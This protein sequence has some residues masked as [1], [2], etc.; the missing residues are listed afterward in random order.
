MN[1]F[2]SAKF[3]QG[4]PE[5]TED[6]A[7][8]KLKDELR[9]SGNRYRN[10]FEGSKDMIFITSLDGAFQD[11][12]PATVE[13]LGY[14]GKEDVLSLAYVEKIFNKKD[15]WEVFKRQI[16]H[17]GFV[18][19]FETH[20]KKADGHLIHCLVSG[21]AVSGKGQ[22]VSGYIGIAKDI[23]ARM[24]AIRNFRQRHR[25][26]RILNSVAY[27]MNKTQDLRT[28]LSTV[29]QKTLEA[30]NLSSGAIFLIDHDVSAF[31]L[32]AQ[33]GLS[34][35]IPKETCRAELHDKLLMESLLNKD[36]VLKPEPIFP[37]FKA[38]LT[39]PGNKET[40]Q[41][42]CFLITAKGKPTG[43][44]GL[45][46][47]PDRDMAGG[48]DFNL[49]GSLGNFLGGAIEKTILIHE[50]RR[51]QAELKELNANLFRL[52]ENERQRIAR[53]LHDEAGQALTG[54]RYSLESIENNL[55][56]EEVRLK[57]LFANV[58]EQIVR[59]YQEIRRISY[60]LHPALLS[61]LGLGPALET[62]LKT[63][64]EKTKINIDFKMVG[65]DRRVDP[66]IENVLYRVSQEAVNN[67]LKHASATEFKLSITKGYPNI[68]LSAEDNGTGIDAKKMKTAK[69]AL[70]LIAMKERVA[71]L[72]G[73]F[74][75]NGKKGNGTRIRIEIPMV[76]LKNGEN[77]DDDFIGG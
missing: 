26:L 51:H 8:S 12:N 13:I 3:R 34:G 36:T 66:E 31:K 29:L 1:P 22:T 11:V 56:D 9:I 72:G 18:K 44:I 17:D 57:G 14:R 21:N 35:A 27:A 77:K 42:T 52:Q 15:H 41:L 68:V 24:D 65:F 7:I 40:E 33:I 55:P 73:T 53:E 10:L 49:M 64:S 2:T 4:K 76:G 47:P 16:D 38:Q 70:G 5:N 19:D 54:I 69:R 20:F 45:Q 37:I 63:I 60:R 32:S 48:Q 25:E 30:L 71:S 50:I 67:T 46:V 23:T 28:I 62:Y 74:K 43:F 39:A 58:K 59:T 75:I 6:P 61:D